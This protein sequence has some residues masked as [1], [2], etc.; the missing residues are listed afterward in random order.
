MEKSGGTQFLVFAVRN[1][2]LVIPIGGRGIG[3]DYVVL[4][5][6]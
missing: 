2:Y 5:G 4:S 6:A 1:M 3:Y